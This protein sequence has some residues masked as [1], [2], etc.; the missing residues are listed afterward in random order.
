LNIPALGSFNV[1]LDYSFIP[2]YGTNTFTIYF[3]GYNTWDFE[4]NE[5]YSAALNLFD[6]IIP[7]LISGFVTGGTAYDITYSFHDVITINIDQIIF[8]GNRA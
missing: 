1:N 3:W 6:E 8:E 7:G 5:N 4:T 2:K